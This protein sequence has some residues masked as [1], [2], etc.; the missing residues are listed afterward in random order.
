MKNKNIVFIDCESAGLR[1]EVF[2]TAMLAA[3]GEKLFDGFYRH[4]ELQTN[5]WLKE[6]VEPNLTGSEF[7]DKETFL[8]AFSMA[9]YAAKDKYGEGE[10]N[11]LA[12]VAHMGSP[13][14]ANFFQ[15]LFINGFLKEF[16]GPYPMLDTAPQ[17]LN[18]GFDPT[19][20]EKYAI[21]TGIVMPEN[22]KQHSAI[23]DS[24]LTRLV[25][26]SLI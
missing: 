10:Y 11:T 5:S 12:A 18:A 14:E 8:R 21:E 23:S 9:W 2:A 4:P 19:S 13:V 7:P 17:L 20:E 16:D 26:N 3:N 6:N 15:E 25:W 24:E 1:G 22:Y